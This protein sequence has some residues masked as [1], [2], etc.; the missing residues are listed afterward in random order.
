MGFS[1][2]VV[3]Q[4]PLAQS[5]LYF[6][7]TG[8]IMACNSGRT[9]LLFILPFPSL[10]LISHPLSGSHSFSAPPRHHLLV[11]LFCPAGEQGL[12]WRDHNNSCNRLA[13]TGAPQARPGPRVQ[14]QAHMCSA[15]RTEILVFCPD[16]AVSSHDHILAPPPQPPFFLISPQTQPP[17]QT[18]VPTFLQDC[19]PGQ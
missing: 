9:S 12:I 19:M 2:V 4:P 3:F 14:C 13:F 6:P 15:G 17:Y 1:A 11:S 18:L 5:E 16:S 7:Q 10:S 8:K